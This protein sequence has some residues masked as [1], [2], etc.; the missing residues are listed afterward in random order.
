MQL[1]TLPYSVLPSTCTA[2]IGNLC[3]ESKLERMVT[4]MTTE[5]KPKV[6]PKPTG[7]VVAP[8]VSEKQLMTDIQ[9]ASAAGDYKTV[10]RIAQELVKYQRSKEQA[11]TEAKQK[12]LAAIVLEVKTAIDATVKKLVDAKKLDLADGVW[13]SADFG[14]KSTACRLIKTTA[15]APR[16]GSGGSGKK[17]D[18]GTEEMLKKHGHMEYKGGQSFQSAYD[19]DTD[20]N[21]RYAIREALLKVEGLTS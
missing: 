15:K 11:E 13:Y 4:Q 10:A 17:Y 14:D 12:A 7:P 8:V 2:G 5:Q 21:K 20:K 16:T 9:K 18:I 6:E 3:T 19:S 1:D